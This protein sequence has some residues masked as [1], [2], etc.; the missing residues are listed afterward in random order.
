MAISA[1]SKLTFCPLVS[2]TVRPPMSRL[3]AETRVSASICCSS[4]QSGGRNSV[5]ARASLFWRYPF[6]H[7]GRLYGRSVSRPIS[8]IAP[9]APDSRNHRA[10]FPAAS[11]PPISAYS[12]WR[13]AI[14]RRGSRR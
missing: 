5:S 13:S 3:L 6:E 14:T 11:P 4:Y 10:Q 1:L 9:S 8:R 2:A 7:G 12:T